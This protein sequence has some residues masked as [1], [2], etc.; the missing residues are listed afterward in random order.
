MSR[1]CEKYLKHSV[2]DIKIFKSLIIY[3]VL[4]YM[5][6]YARIKMV[7]EFCDRRN[8][9]IDREETKFILMSTVWAELPIRG[10]SA[11]LIF[12]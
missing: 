10:S 1:L 2:F 3:N 4:T 5:Y 9:G 8:G 11:L 12:D 6:R 7:L